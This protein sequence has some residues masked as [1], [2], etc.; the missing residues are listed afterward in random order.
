MVRGGR[1]LRNDPGIKFYYLEIKYIN[2]WLNY[3]G[4]HSIPEGKGKISTLS[5]ILASWASV[6][7]SKRGTRLKASVITT[8]CGWGIERGNFQGT[9][10]CFRKC[11]RQCFNKWKWWFEWWLEWFEEMILCGFKWTGRGRG[12]RDTREGGMQSSHVSVAVNTR[13]QIY[14]TTLYTTLQHSTVTCRLD[15]FNTQHLKSRITIITQNHG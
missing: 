1:G 4:H 12:S 11:L 15:I 9:R 10:L 13:T 7:P 5:D 14:T 8:P 6:K 3:S 2:N